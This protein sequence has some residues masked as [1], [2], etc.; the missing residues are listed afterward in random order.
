MMLLIH[1]G[2]PHNWH[3]LARAWS[4]EPLVITGLA[5][6][7]VLFTLGQRRKKS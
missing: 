3:D 5:L 6:T 7:A 4:F 2:Q 1:G